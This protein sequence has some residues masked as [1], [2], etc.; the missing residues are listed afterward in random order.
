MPIYPASSLYPWTLAAY[1][2]P[3]EVPFCSSTSVA[4]ITPRQTVPAAIQ[5]PRTCR[6]LYDPKPCCCPDWVIEE[7]L[8]DTNIDI[9]KEPELQAIL[10]QDCVDCYTIDEWIEDKAAADQAKEEPSS[11]PQ[12]VFDAIMSFKHEEEDRA[13]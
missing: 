2:T 4:A 11:F 3:D 7:M 13:D 8:N 12:S 6:S 1:S 10:S 5:Q 9:E